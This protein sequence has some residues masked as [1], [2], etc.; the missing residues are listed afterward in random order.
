MM[1]ARKANGRKR[2]KRSTG[3]RP[4]ARPRKQV[5]RRRAK[6][7]VSLP[8]RV[9]KAFEDKYYLTLPKLCDA[10]EVSHLTVR[11]YV[12]RGMLPFRVVGVGTK[13]MHRLFTLA[14]VK[15]LWRRIS[16]APHVAR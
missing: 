4:I 7:P 2:P 14:D 8:P 13:R 6:A 9:L 16:N 10:M 1:T 15:V 11:A 3:R 12:D 5:K